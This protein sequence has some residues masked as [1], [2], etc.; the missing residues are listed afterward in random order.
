[1]ATTRLTQPIRE[2]IMKKLLHRAFLDRAQAVV[3]RQADFARRVYE[4]ALKPHL[5]SIA[6]VPAGWLPTDDDIKVSFGTDYTQLDFGSGL[7]YSVHATLRACGAKALTGPGG[8]R[9]E[10]PF[11]S[12]FRGQ[13]LKVYDHKHPL[14]EEFRDLQVEQEALVA[15]VEKAQRTMKATL[16]SVTTVKKLIEVWP[17]VEEFAK[18][19]LE[20]GERKAI[21]PAIPRAELNKALGLPPQEK[22]LD[23]VAGGTVA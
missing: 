13:C 20:S 19:Y 4:D 1:M 6:A 23:E 5:T 18:H 15:E 8:N 9:V 17:E 3:D 22:V 16:E 7:S 2:A 21:L 10:L 14:A 12:K 11:P